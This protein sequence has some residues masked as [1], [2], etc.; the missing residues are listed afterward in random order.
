MSARSLSVRTRLGLAAIAAL[1]VI[2]SS[3]P[4]LAGQPAAAPAEIMPAARAAA[5]VDAAAQGLDYLPGEVIVKFKDGVEPE[6]Q[7]RALDALRSRP[8]TG[9][10][11]WVGEV[12]ML[13][14]ASQPDA[15]VLA[16]QLAAQ[17]EVAYAEPN[18]LRHKNVTPNDTGYGPRQ[19]NLQ[20]LDMP[21]AWD[22]NPGANADV[23]VAIVD[24]GITTVNSR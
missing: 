4:H 19:W 1:A 2:L 17:P 21:R 12:A 18:F 13:R 20:S 22:I 9:D 15:R 3:P 10:L 23:I 11:E 14:D 5:F 7:Q 6:R 8:S 24:T 16:E